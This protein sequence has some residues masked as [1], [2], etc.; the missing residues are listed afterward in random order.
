MWYSPRAIVSKD[1]Q[2]LKVREE[3]ASVDIASSDRHTHGV[4]VCVDGRDYFGQL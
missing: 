2:S 4:W 1:V 3:A